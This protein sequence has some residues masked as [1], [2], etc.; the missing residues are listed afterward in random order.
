MVNLEKFSIVDTGHSTKNPI[1]YACP[2]D[3][4]SAASEV[5]VVTVGDSWTWGLDMTPNDD[6]T[7]RLQHHYGSVIAR[8]LSADWL[9]LGQGGSGNFWL[10]DRVQ[11]LAEI[12]PTLN[13]QHI[14]VI[15]TFTETGRAVASR[16]DIDFYHFLH[17]NPV[18]QFLP[19]LNQVCIDRVISA[20]ALFDNVTLR[21]GT[22]FVDYIGPHCDAVLPQSW[23]ELLC[24]QH[25]VPYTESCCVV[26]SWV[27]DSLQQL[28]ALAPDRVEY[29]KFLNSLVDPAIA[30]ANL[31]RQV[32]GIKYIGDL[33]NGSAI[34]G[35]PKASGHQ[36]WADYILKNL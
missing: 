6:N 29:M 19:Y 30:R 12:I 34:G 7:H 33:K 31:F 36:V 2:F 9:N 22:N 32:P 11:E 35:H 26:S 4:V 24:N 20:L 28:I 18:D 23:L 15:C 5:L 21:I 3:F 16:Q 1:K 14:Y 10:Y 8:A 25:N 13:Y 17:H 27:I